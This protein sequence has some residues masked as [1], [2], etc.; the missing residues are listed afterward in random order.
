M[1]NITLLTE[2]GVQ[3][4]LINKLDA[5]NIERLCAYVKLA[6]VD[7]ATLLK[8]LVS[9]ISVEMQGKPGAIFLF[10]EGVATLSQ[11][12]NLNPAAVKEVVEDYE[13]NQDFILAV[14]HTKHRLLQQQEENM[15]N[16]NDYMEIRS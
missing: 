4:A 8:L 16:R 3:E 13:T 6:T 14:R 12:K 7:H 9:V 15:L 5:S 11:L 10:T 1:Q 2:L